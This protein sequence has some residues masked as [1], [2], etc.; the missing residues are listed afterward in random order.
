MIASVPLHTS[1][2]VAKGTIN[3]T[4]YKSFRHN[5][6]LTAS[7]VKRIS[8]KQT[9]AFIENAENSGNKNYS[10]CVKICLDE[11]ENLS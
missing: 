10:D 1:T 8:I 2:K 3:E 7:N 6:E 9:Q 11:S 5:N 4:I